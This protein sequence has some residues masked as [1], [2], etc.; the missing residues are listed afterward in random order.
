M[1]DA[2]YK[3]LIQYIQTIVE[4]GIITD[5]KS[6]VTDIFEHV[7]YELGQ[8]YIDCIKKYSPITQDQMTSYCSK[9]D[10]Y[11]GG[12]KYNYG[13]ITTSP[14]NFRYLFH[15]H[16]ILTHMKVQQNEINIVEIGCGYGG[17]FLAMYE[18][19]SVYDVII[20]EYHLIDLPI[21]SSLQQL[22]LSKFSFTTK[23]V[24]HSAYTYGNNIDTTNLFL[25]SNYCFSE[26]DTI[27]QQQYI[28]QL[29]PKVL[30]GFMTWNHILVYDFGFS[31]KVEEEY[32][33]TS[34]NPIHEL[35]NKYIYF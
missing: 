5:F 4:S 22:Y 14:T 12:K 18:L 19:S 26:I 2:M 27:H 28:N 32:P 30:H 21:I 24:F 8:N 9:N 25:I 3:R 7:S 10:K 6:N 35:N 13:W 16:L 31:L 20:N 15:A 29:F 23:L 34:M 17:L 11:G 33:L 1:S